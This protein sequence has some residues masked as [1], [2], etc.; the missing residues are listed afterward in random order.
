MKFSIIRSTVSYSLVT[1]LLLLLFGCDAQIT[2]EGYK[3][4]DLGETSQPDCCVAIKNNININREEVEVL[5]KIKASDTGFSTACDEEYVLDIFGEDACALG[6]D[7]INIVEEEQPDYFW[8]TCYRAKA[9]FLRLK[10]R[11]YAGSI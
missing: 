8:S 3:A 5:G 7:I 6:A 2:R 1:V 10:D 11:Q 9:E 4:E